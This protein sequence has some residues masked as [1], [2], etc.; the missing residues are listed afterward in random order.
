MGARPADFLK[1]HKF[2]GTL[3]QGYTADH[4]CRTAGY[5]CTIWNMRCPHTMTD[6]SHR[7]VPSTISSHSHAT[8]YHYGYASFQRCCTVVIPATND[9]RPDRVMSDARAAYKWASPPYA[10]AAE[11]CECS[12]HRSRSACHSADRPDDNGGLSASLALVA[13]SPLIVGGPSFVILSSGT[14]SSSCSPHRLSC[15]ARF[16]PPRLARFAAKRN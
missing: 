14:S 2:E 4:R 3:E 13:L 10:T 9:L 5:S 15:L 12:L 16:L 1:W 11:H 6:D 7:D 8:L